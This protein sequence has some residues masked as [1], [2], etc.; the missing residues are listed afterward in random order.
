MGQG[1]EVPSGLRPLLPAASVLQVSLPSA[2]TL[3]PALG[4]EG[5]LC[6]HHSKAAMQLSPRP[7]QEWDM[8]E[9]CG[10]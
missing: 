10:W 8:A 2:S 5:R 1:L 4:S 9:G 6:V 3:S 7:E